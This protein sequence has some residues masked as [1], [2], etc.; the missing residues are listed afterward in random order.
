VLPLRRVVRLHS[1]TGTTGQPSWVGLSRRDVAL[2]TD[3]TARAL[4]TE[5]LA[6]EDVLVH[7]TS[8]G[9]FVGGLPVKD[10]VERIGATF[11]PIGT[12]ASE[13]AVM[14]LRSL[15]ANALHATP[16]YALY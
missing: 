15:G 16:S 8:L 9:L 1:S 12:G 5:G 11:V 3:I 4:A 6:P 14:A 2:W 10:A 13:K 7:G